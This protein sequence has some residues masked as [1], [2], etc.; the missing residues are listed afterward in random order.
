MPRLRQPAASSGYNV[1]SALRAGDPTAK[2]LGDPRR[3]AVPSSSKWWPKSGSSN[4][5]RRIGVLWRTGMPAGAPQGGLGLLAR[6]SSAARAPA[7]S[8]RSPTGST[9]PYVE[10]R[11]SY[12][13]SLAGILNRRRV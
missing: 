4:L 3:L 10:G 8:V 6:R 13:S 2:R 1:L 7:D 9:N 5:L 11:A 12:I